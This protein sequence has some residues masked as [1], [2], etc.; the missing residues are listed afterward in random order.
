MGD[1][2]GYIAFGD[3]ELYARG[4]LFSALR[5]LHYC[6]AAKVT[7]LTDR[8]RVFDGYPI[9]TVEL[10]A[11]RMTEM[12]FGGRYRFGI[13]AAG[14]VDLLKH[15]DRLFLMD[16]DMYPVGDMS[17]C[18][19]R[20]SPSHSVMNRLE[21]R[22]KVP[23]RA[24]EGRHFML[25]DKMLTGDE[26]MWSSG[27]LGVHNS[28]LPALADAYRA[29]E[30]LI[31]VVSAHTL[32]QFCIGVALSRNGCRIAPHRLPLRNYTTRGRKLFARRR[33]QTFFAG[34]GHLAVSQ[35]IEQAASYRL[36]RAPID[37]WKQPD[38]WHF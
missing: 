38:I 21:G 14:L 26:P 13:K 9:Q 2:F 1:S 4:A 32:E 35:Q 7:V 19:D 15:C 36:W 10:T 6:P 30:Q 5:L 16:T 17:G 27:V 34:N 23:Y 25:G 37:L 12:S 31:G 24:I 8:T 28:A 18:F 20:I 3:D 33:L 22:P 29:I 11:S